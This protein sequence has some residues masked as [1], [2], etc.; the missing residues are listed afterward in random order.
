MAN[1]FNDNTIFMFGNRLDLQNY[2]KEKFL[3]EYEDSEKEARKERPLFDL[4]SEFKKKKDKFST[5][6]DNNEYNKIIKKCFSEDINNNNRSILF[7]SSGKSVGTCSLN[8]KKED[9]AEAIYKIARAYYGLPVDFLGPTLDMQEALVVANNGVSVMM[10]DGNINMLVLSNGIDTEEAD[11]IANSLDRD[12]SCVYYV[13]SNNGKFRGPLVA[14]EVINYLNDYIN[15]N[16][17]EYGKISSKDYVDC[18]I[19]YLNENNINMI[20][21]YKNVANKYINEEYSDIEEFEL[22]NPFLSNEDIDSL[23]N[24]SDKK[25]D[26]KYFANSITRIVELNLRSRIVIDNSIIKDIDFD[27]LDNLDGYAVLTDNNTINLYNYNSKNKS[28]L[29]DRAVYSTDDFSITSGYYVN[30]DQFMEGIL[31]GIDKDTIL[32]VEDGKESDYNTM[33]EIA[34]SYCNARGAIKL[35]TVDGNVLNDMFA[36]RDDLIRF[37]KDYKLKVISKDNK[38]YPVKRV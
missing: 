30:I 23:I 14:N 8:D 28:V 4:R 32:F 17:H 12:N 5:L 33:N 6:S 13:V 11:S 16:K 3:R 15:S 7:F 25:R 20:E 27:V 10:I 35:Q 21:Y 31:N 36:N 29:T 19:E 38:N 24:S 26:I 9:Y 1:I 18:L 34:K 37:F 22:R 2:Q